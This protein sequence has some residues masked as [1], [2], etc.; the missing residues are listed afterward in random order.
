MEIK[1]PL[2]GTNKKPD[3]SFTDSKLKEW[4]S[5]LPD[6]ISKRQFVS[7]L[8]RKMGFPFPHD[9]EEDEKHIIRRLVLRAVRIGLVSSNH[10]H[11]R[12]LYVH[13][14]QEMPISH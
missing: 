14:P 11:F 1:L 7:F 10:K 4:V 8:S 9:Q 12:M 6:E 3:W 5:E 2:T 13:K